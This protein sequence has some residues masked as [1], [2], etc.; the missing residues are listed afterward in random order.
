MDKPVPALPPGNQQ[1]QVHSQKEGKLGLEGEHSAVASPWKDQENKR[2][3][4]QSRD[5]Q[6][7]QNIEAGS[8]SLQKVL[9]KAADDGIRDEVTHSPSFK[10]HPGHIRL[11]TGA[12]QAWSEMLPRTHGQWLQ[13]WG[14]F[15][16]LGHFSVLR[17]LA[18]LQ[19]KINM[20]IRKWGQGIQ[21]YLGKK[22]Q[23]IKILQAR[24]K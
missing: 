9:S 16:Q 23:R 10:V 4:W 13:G 2:L 12:A 15:G 17:I 11:L 3:C 8:G 5:D 21:Y 19:S 14:C 24:T 1:E 22:F 6:R 18:A 20:E 7:G